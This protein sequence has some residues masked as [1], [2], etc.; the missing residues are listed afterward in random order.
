MKKL[1]LIRILFALLTIVGYSLPADQARAQEDKQRILLQARLSANSPVLRNGVEWRI[2]GT[3]VQADGDLPE[4]GF[5]EGGPKAFNMA[6]GEYIIHASFGHAGAVKRIRIGQEASVEEFVF[7]A[8]GLRLTANTSDDVPVPERA[9]RFDIYEQEIQEDG[10]RNLLARGVKP[11]QVIAFPAG[12]YHVVSRYGELNATVRAELR[13]LPGQLTEAELQHRAARL[14]FRLVRQA[15][16]DAVADTAWSILTETGEVIRESSSTFP[17]MILA[18][19]NY[20][21]IA[22]HS[23][24]V[25]S[26]DFTVRSG[27]NK[28]VEVLVPN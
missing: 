10:E 17:S 18:E 28:D 23:D 12:T 9:L 4:L 19:G 21:A 24:A 14:T 2:F 1:R 27:F 8:G 16:G 25:Y 3:E 5:A 20:T 6:S 11:N 7:N 15:G 26:Q 22:K 13:V